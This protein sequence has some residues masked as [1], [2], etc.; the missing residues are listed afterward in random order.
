M[1]ASLL[2][3]FWIFFKIGLFTFGG[4]YAMI[5]LIEQYLIGGGYIASEDI[6]YQLIG[7]A[8]STPGPIAVNMATFIGINQFSDY[9]IFVGIIGAVFTTLGVVLPSFI[10]ILLIASLG[11]K[12]IDSKIAQ[13]AFVCLKPAIIGLI[14]KVAFTLFFR[15]IFPMVDFEHLSF[16]FSIFTYQN[17]II[18]GIIIG[19]MRFYKKI[20]PIQIILLSAVLGVVVYYIV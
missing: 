5:P 10:I 1:I 14:A 11:S 12:A 17:I 15:L 7:L 8:E 6:L 20:S 16:D 9:G 18:F 2:N 19:I 13:H 4:G 3:L